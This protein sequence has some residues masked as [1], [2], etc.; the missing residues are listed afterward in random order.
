MPRLSCSDAHELVGQD[1]GREQVLAR[2]CL[3]RLLTTGL[4]EQNRRKD[5]AIDEV[6]VVEQVVVTRLA[7]ATLDFLRFELREHSGQ[8][9]LRVVRAVHVRAATVAVLS[10]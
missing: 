10:E 4:V 6:V 2:E 7:T 1:L 9:G 8:A 5:A 3:R